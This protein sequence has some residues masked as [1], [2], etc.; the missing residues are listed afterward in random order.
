MIRIDANRLYC[1][2]LCYLFYCQACEYDNHGRIQD[3]GKGGGGGPGKTWCFRAHARDVFFSLL[4]KF[5]GP[6]K[7]GG[8]GPDPQDPPPPR[9]G[10]ALDNEKNIPILLLLKRNILTQS[11]R[12]CCP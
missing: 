10:S 11:A 7:G 3:F 1:V 9:P 12:E 6:P 5:G 2:G 8:G 4:M